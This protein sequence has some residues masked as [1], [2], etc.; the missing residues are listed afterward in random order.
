[1]LE[2]AESAVEDVSSS[3]EES[4]NDASVKTASGC[5]AEC[6]SSEGV[7]EDAGVE[8]ADVY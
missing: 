3:S 7:D 2:V 4:W 6:A 5:G 8:D 1:M